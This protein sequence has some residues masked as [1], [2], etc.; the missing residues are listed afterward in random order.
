[1]VSIAAFQAIDPGTSG[2][3]SQIPVRRTFSFLRR[4]EIIQ[5]KTTR[6][7]GRYNFDKNCLS[8]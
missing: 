7:I 5:D 3:D 2:F 1:M 4:V 6:N 8:L